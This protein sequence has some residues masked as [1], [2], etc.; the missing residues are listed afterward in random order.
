MCKNTEITGNSI[1]VEV[2]DVND[3][4]FHHIHQVFRE[5]AGK[6]CIQASDKTWSYADLWERTQRT[7]GSL[8]AAG[9]VRGDRIVAQAGKCPELV[10]L[11]LACLQTG[12]VYVP[13]NDSYTSKEVQYF[14]D[15]T[16]PSLLV[17]Q[18]DPVP[19]LRYEGPTWTLDEKGGG[20]L[21]ERVAEATA[22]ARIEEMSASDIAAILYT[23][24]TT[25]R[26]KGAV[27]NHGNLLSNA[28]TLIKYW[29]WQP[30][31]VL[32]HALPI[33]HVHGLFVALHCVLLTGT[34]MIWHERFEVNRVLQALPDVTVLMGVPTFYSRMLSHKEFGKSHIQDMRLFISGSAPLSEQTFA[35]FERRTGHRILERYGMSEA[36]MITSNP[37]DGERVPGTVGF[38][39]PDVQLR[40]ANEA[41]ETMPSGEIGGIEIKGPNVFPEYW[42]MPE[43]TTQEFT[44]DGFFKTG[45]VGYQEEDGRVLIVGREKDLIISGGLNVYPAEIE[46]AIDELDGVRETAVV[47]AP[48]PDFGEAVVAVVV[49]NRSIQLSEL[50]LWLQ[51]RLARFKHPK[52]VVQLDEL[53]RNAMGKIQ[54]NVLREQVA[55]LFVE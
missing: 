47:G 19:S 4:L 30:T 36:L 15:D 38:P 31:D 46:S 11:Y 6:N 42:Q 9:I 10:A 20:S 44:S 22:D 41:G 27:L 49:A 24:G 28:L 17:L 39:L 45:D 14:V 16:R 51:D 40:I 23:S 8:K 3:S 34:S 13:M 26:S 5:S 48:H 55:S 54:K 43:Q 18:D 2:F 50:R 25:G 32:L 37:Y 29:H 7:A 53:P 12:T 52:A 35:L 1:R 33:Y 21:S